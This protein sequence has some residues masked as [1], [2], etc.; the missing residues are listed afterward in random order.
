MT[1][2]FVGYDRPNHIV[3]SFYYKGNELTSLKIVHPLIEM[4][5]ELS[6]KYISHTIVLV[7][8]SGVICIV[9]KSVNN[10]FIIVLHNDYMVF[11]MNECTV[12]STYVLVNEKI[13]TQIICLKN[14]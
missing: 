7:L 2:N 5:T 8:H 9:Q 12:H 13:S 1:K 14:T 6:Q 11:N 10:H 3:I 4:S